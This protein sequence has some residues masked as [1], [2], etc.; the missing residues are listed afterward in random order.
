MDKKTQK[1]WWGKQES[2]GKYF[3][4][5]IWNSICQPKKYGGLGFRKFVGF[6]KA[7]L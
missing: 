3:T 4:P 1:F 2:K 6:N 7:M 5:I